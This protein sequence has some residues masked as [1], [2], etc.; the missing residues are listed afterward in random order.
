VVLVEHSA[1]F[2]AEGLQHGDWDG[3]KDNLRG[4]FRVLLEEEGNLLAIKLAG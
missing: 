3:R 2:G 1:Y 4:G